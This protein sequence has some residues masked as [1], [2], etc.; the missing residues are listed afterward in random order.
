MVSKDVFAQSIPLNEES[1]IRL[2][3]LTEKERG[4]YF[5]SLELLPSMRKL[6]E[7]DEDFFWQDATGEDTMTYCI[8][9]KLTNEYMGYCIYQNLCSDEP[10]I[11]VEIAESF[12][13]QGFGQEVIDVLITHFFD[14]TDCP[15]L[16]WRL[17]R[18]NGR[19]THLA[20]KMGGRLLREHSKMLDM[21]GE[22][23]ALLSEEDLQEYRSFDTL[24]YVI[25]RPIK[26]D[27]K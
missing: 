27:L 24:V 16:F 1:R 15:R 10:E 9:N 26:E 11:G 14:R 18:R 20:E 3:V 7:V 19:S 22:K 5:K 4:L 12:Q 6:G 13:D 21:L 25:D 23:A 8:W 2:T 17:F